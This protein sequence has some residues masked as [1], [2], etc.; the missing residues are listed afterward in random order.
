MQTVSGPQTSWT[1]DLG[2]ETLSE[3][4]LIIGCYPPLV[5]SLPIVYPAK[6]PLLRGFLRQYVS[7]VKIAECVVGGEGLEP[8][9]NPL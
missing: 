7:M 8:P 6:P 4:G 1:L 2:S 5:A 9:T 3:I